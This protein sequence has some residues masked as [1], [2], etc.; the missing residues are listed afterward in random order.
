MVAVGGLHLISLSLSLWLAWAFR[1][2]SLMPPDMNPLEDNLTAR[3][4][5]KRNKSSV[6]T[7]AS[8]E[9]DKGFSTPAGN[10]P[11]VD[12]L[13]SDNSRAPTVPFAHTREGSTVSLGSRD[14]RGDLPSRQYQI[15]PGNS[16]RN[17]TTSMGPKRM[18]RPLS[19]Y[20]GSYAE[21][22]VNDP[23]TAGDNP[24][25][26]GSID[27]GRAGKFTETWLPTDSLVSRTNQRNRNAAAGLR[28]SNRNS[29]SY[30]ALSQ[31]YNM[32]DSSD[33]EYDDG[34]AVG[35]NGRGERDLSRGHHPNPLASNP[36]QTSR[37]FTNR[38]KTPFRSQG[39]AQS[40]EKNIH[41]K[42]ANHNYGLIPQSQDIVDQ[43][44]A[45]LSGGR[46]QRKSNCSQSKSGFYSKPY[47]NLKSAT[48][49]IIVGG[50]RKISS[51]N[52]YDTSKHFPKAYG[53]RNVSGKVAEEGR[54]GN[55]SSKYG[56][57]ITKNF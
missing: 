36:L 12:L 11:R 33:S 21:V 50:D 17:S 30:A 26:R 22:P 25:T 6:T 19:A 38:A 27:N 55:M 42:A 1:R 43:T 32:E 56:S 29:A 53:R 57:Y 44:T 9:S 4:K 52:D 10:H 7:V 3:P 8:T 24:V 16:P 5:H 35:D 41:S 40:V 37:T 18:S 14:S 20:R 28:T 2:I 39:P 34:N 48:Q 31:R 46:Q 15:M 45:G 23:S 47:G 49:P 54:A 51:G 13:Y